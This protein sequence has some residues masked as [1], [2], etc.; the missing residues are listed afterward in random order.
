MHFICLSKLSNV[1][2]CFKAKSAHN[3]YVSLPK[4]VARVCW[5]MVKYI[6]LVEYE[7]NTC[8]MN[9]VKISFPFLMSVVPFEINSNF[10][11]KLQFDHIY[12]NTVFI[13]MYQRMT[14][15]IMYRLDKDDNYDSV[16]C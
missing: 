10:T 15:I 13:C 5:N 9:V 6:C 7:R 12:I 16:K 3:Y 14:I 8:Q 2:S 4:R 11:S 1:I